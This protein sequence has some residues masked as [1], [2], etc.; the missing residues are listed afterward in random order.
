M[1][2]HSASF[3]VVFK[4]L[5]PSTYTVMWNQTEKISGGILY[6]MVGGYLRDLPN[7]WL[8]QSLSAYVVVIS[9]NGERRF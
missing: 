9:L 7:C 2:K 1:V 3:V 5:S 4:V 6:L 8:W